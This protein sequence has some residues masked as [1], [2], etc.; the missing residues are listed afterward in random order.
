VYVVERETE[1]RIACENRLLEVETRL[2]KQNSVVIAFKRD[3]AE[4]SLRRLGLPC[5][6]RTFVSTN[7]VHGGNNLRGM[8][9]ETEQVLMIPGWGRGEYATETRQILAAAGVNPANCLYAPSPETDRAEGE[10]NWG[11]KEAEIV[12]DMTYTLGGLL[13]RATS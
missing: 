7:D 6:G 4:L 10:S 12:K 1:D 2:R 13:D 5:T 11:R 8:K 3:E 9:L